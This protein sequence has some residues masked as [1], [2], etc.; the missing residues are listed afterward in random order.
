MGYSQLI[1]WHSIV[2][3][4]TYSLTL[5]PEYRASKSSSDSKSK[6]KSDGKQAA[7][8][9]NTNGM[10][11]KGRREVKSGGAGWFMFILKVGAFSFLFNAVTVQVV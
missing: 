6:S 5:K 4:N 2:S 10:S 7:M 3:V 8:N 9:A 11:G 1:E